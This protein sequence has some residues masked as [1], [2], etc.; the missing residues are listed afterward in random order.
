MSVWRICWISETRLQNSWGRKKNLWR[1]L[2]RPSCSSRATESRLPRTA[3]GQLLNISEDGDSATSLG[4]L[5]RCSATLAGKKGFLRGSLCPV[6]G[7]HDKEL[8]PQA[9]PWHGL[10]A[11]SLQVFIC[12]NM[13]W[14]ETLMRNRNMNGRMEEAGCCSEATCGWFRIGVGKFSI[15]SDVNFAC[16]KVFIWFFVVFGM[17]YVQMATPSLGSD[18]RIERIFVFSLF[19]LFWDYH[20]GVIKCYGCPGCLV[21]FF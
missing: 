19:C 10:L 3:S 7:H 11:A 15:S 18:T 4:N 12:V 20:I 14:L 17:W 6:T 16:L 1:F 21:W 5:G 9:K 13:K 2:V 8:Q